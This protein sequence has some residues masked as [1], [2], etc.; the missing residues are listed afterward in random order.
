MVH[1]EVTADG[2]SERVMSAASIPADDDNVV[3]LFGRDPFLDPTKASKNC[4]R[5]PIEIREGVGGRR[6]YGILGTD[7]E[8]LPLDGVRTHKTTRAL[9]MG[10]RFICWDYPNDSAQIVRL[11]CM[12]YNDLK[13]AAVFYSRTPKPSLLG[14]AIGL[15]D[16]R[17]SM[18]DGALVHNNPAVT[19][20]SI[21]D[22]KGRPFFDWAW[23]LNC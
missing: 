4:D 19:L 20:E 18:D 11:G 13:D 22:A 2:R 5:Y 9:S 3:P 7:G 6:T 17:A 10:D 15:L 8:L 12:D 23:G 16:Y 14:Q 21:T 1:F